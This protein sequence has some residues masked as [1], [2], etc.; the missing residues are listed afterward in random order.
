M[1]TLLPRL[2]QMFLGAALLVI[3]AMAKV[4]A[5]PLVFFIGALIVG[6]TATMLLG[7]GAGTFMGLG[8]LACTVAFTV[9]D[10]VAGQLQGADGAQIVARTTLAAA[11]FCGLLSLGSL[12]GGL[13]RG[14]I[15]RQDAP[16]K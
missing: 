2:F 6:F 13:L 12:V 11:I 7:R 15:S 16:K 3:I 10:M 5:P 9:Y 1:R 8:V 4:A 14:R